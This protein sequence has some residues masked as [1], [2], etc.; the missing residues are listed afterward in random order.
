MLLDAA[1]ID[2]LATPHR[3]GS[4]NR[5][6]PLVALSLATALAGQAGAALADPPAKTLRL[7]GEALTAADPAPKAFVIDLTVSPGDSGAQT[8]LEGWLASTAAPAIS[9]EVSGACIETHCTLTADLDGPKLTITGDFGAAAGPAAARFTLKDSDDKLVGEGTATLKPLGGEV[10]GFGPLA[11][12]GAASA[13]ELDE[14]LTWSHEAPTSGTPP[15]DEPP[16]SFQRET[17][18]TWQGE[19]G[20]L[21]TGLI[22]TADLAQLRANEAAAKKAAGWTALGDAAHGWSAGYPAAVLPNASRAAGKAG[23]EQRFASADGNAVL[24][25][26]VGPPMSDADFDAFVEKITA[27]RDTRSGVNMTRVNG[28][29]Q[30]R[31]VEG[32]V[33]N[34]EAYHNREGGLARI[35]FTYPDKGGDA[36][37][38]YETILQHGLTVTDDLKP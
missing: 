34:V 8:S 32:G 29:L 2:A 3:A 35:E 26:A 36:Y 16:D 12:P 27:D 6:R 25:V 37:A 22:F 13:A 19:Q 28:D 9:G 4:G 21:A 31:Y 7:I 11:E 1:L 18:A 20:R 30:L 24:V 38:P 14:L 10:A 15:G 33:V 5:V 23:P 17:L